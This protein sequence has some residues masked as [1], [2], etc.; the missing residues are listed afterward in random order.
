MTYKEM[1]ERN[2][3]EYEKLMKSNVRRIRVDA[4]TWRTWGNGSTIDCFIEDALKRVDGVFAKRIVKSVTFNEKKKV[5][6]VVLKNGSVGIA[7]CSQGDEY[8]MRIGFCVAFTSALF[9]SKTQV[10]KTVDKYLS[11]DNK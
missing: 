2:M 1:F 7:R 11:K 3:A 10:Q 6:T 8:D 9:G 5:T 4:D